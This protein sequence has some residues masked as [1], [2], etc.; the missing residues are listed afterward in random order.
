[1]LEQYERK[2]LLGW[3]LLEL[4][5]RVIREKGHYYGLCLWFLPFI[6]PIIGF[7]TNFGTSSRSNN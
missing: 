3:R 6:L 7:E 4:P 1:M 5:N 2:I